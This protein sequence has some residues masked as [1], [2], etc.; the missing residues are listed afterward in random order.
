MIDNAPALDFFTTNSIAASD[1]IITPV[2]EDGFSKKGLK[3][4]LDVIND[5]KEEHDLTHVKFLGTFLTQVDPRTNAVK[6]RIREYQNIIPDLLFKTYIRRDTKVAQMESKFIPM[7]E[8]S[9]DSNALIDYCHLLLE[10]D[11]L[12]VPQREKLLRSIGEAA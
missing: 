7:L 10:M 12:Q 11:I 6:E 1:Y 4:I 9:L 3:E 5:I 2:R 8:H